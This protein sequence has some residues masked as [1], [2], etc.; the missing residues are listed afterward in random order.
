M[1]RIKI[2]KI[3]I[4]TGEIKLFSFFFLSNC[5]YVFNLKVNVSPL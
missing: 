3:V 5:L 1:G 2:L 4:L